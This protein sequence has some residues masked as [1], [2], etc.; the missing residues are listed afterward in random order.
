MSGIQSMQRRLVD[1]VAGKGHDLRLQRVAHP[2]DLLE[3]RLADLAREVKVGKMDDRQPFQGRRQSRHVETALGE[4]QLQ[5]LVARQMDEEMM[6]MIGDVQDVA[7]G[8]AAAAVKAEDRRDVAPG[9]RH[10]QRV[11]RVAAALSQQRTR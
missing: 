9:A 10:R 1:E 8:Q 2:H 11:T 7:R 3:K 6:R 5:A 4:V